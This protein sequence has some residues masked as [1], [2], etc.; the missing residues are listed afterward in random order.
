MASSLQKFSEL[1][2]ALIREASVFDCAVRARS[3]E[4]QAGEIVAYVVPSGAF[5]EQTV[6]ANLQS[7]MP[8]SPLPDHYVLLSGL[9]FSNDG[10]VDEEALARIGIVNEQVAKA[11]EEKLL[12]L[13][14]VQQA[15]VVI[16]PQVPKLRPLHISDLLPNTK[17]V[18]AQQ[19]KPAPSS[20]AEVNEGSPSAHKRVAISHGGTLCN[21]GQVPPTLQE[22]LRRAAETTPPRSITC[23]QADGSEIIHTYAELLED[24]EHI[25][26]GL[27][28]LG[29][30]PGDKVIFQLD[31]NQD[32]IPAFW[33]C[34]LGGFVPAPI[35]IAPTYRELNSTI[36]K[37][38]NSWGMLDHPVVLAREGLADSVRNAGVLLDLE[39]FRVET[40]EKLRASAVDNHWHQSR[41]EDVC[42]M[43]LTSGSTGLPKGVLQTHRSLMHRSASTAELT[44]FDATD[45][46]IN[47]FPLDHVGG[48]VMAHLMALF[49]CA[50]QIHIPTE[51]IL[52]EPL[53]WLDLIDRHRATVT[54]APNFAFGLIND[55]DKQ[56][57]LRQWDLSCMRFILNGGEAIV[58]KTARRFLEVLAKHGLRA[59]AMHPS[60]GMSETCSGIAFSDRCSPNTLHDEDSFVEVG[61]PIPG[62]SFRI[63]D[64]GD[65]A[66]EEGQIGRLQVTGLPVTTGYYK[67][68]ELNQESFSQDGWF[69]TGD[70]AMLNSGRLTITGRFKDVIIINGA[71]FFSHEIE[72]V[73]EEVPG[74]DVSYTAAFAVR[75]ANDNT[76]RLCIMFHPL[77]ADWSEQLALIKRIREVL[78][79]KAGVNAAWIIPVERSDIPKTAIGKIQ[80][81]VLRQRFEAREFEFIAKRIDLDTQSSNTLPNWFFQKA[82]TVQQPRILDWKVVEGSYLVFADTGALA[83]NLRREIG[84]RAVDW[85]EVAPGEAFERLERSRYRLN[86]TERSDYELLFAALSQDQVDV[87]RI[88]HLW[89]YGADSAKSE[90]SSEP[91]AVQ[92]RGLCSV[93]YLAQALDTAHS[94]R[95]I[96]FFV[97][98][99]R[100]QS[101][102][103]EDRVACEKATLLGLLKTISLEMPLLECRHVDLEGNS[104]QMDAQF[105]SQELA[106][107]KS[108][109][110]VAYRGTLRLQALLSQVDMLAQ[111][112]QPVLITES[113]LYLIT[114]GLGGIGTNLSEYLTQH[115]KAKLILV[116]RTVLPDQH[117][118][119]EAADQDPVVARRMRNYRRLE[120]SGADFMYRSLDI[121]DLDRLREVVSE[122]EKRWK[123]PLKGI[124]HLAG[125][126]NL[127][128]YWKVMDRHWLRVESISTFEGMFAPKVYGTRALFD[129]ISKRPEVLFIAFSS[130]LSYFGSSTW[131]AYSAASRFLDAYCEARRKTSHPNT[132]CFNWT[133]WDGVGMSEG[134]PASVA[135]AYRNMGYT[136]M[137]VS[138]ALDS[139]M[140]GLLR[141]QHQLAIGLDLASPHV[142]RHTMHQSST[143]HVLSGYYTLR[144][145]FSSAVKADNIDVRDRSGAK[146]QCRLVNVKPT[147]LADIS[148]FSVNGNRMIEI[149][150]RIQPRNETEEQ[151]VRIWREVLAVSNVSMDDK[152]FELGGDS[153]L[154]LRVANRMREILGVSVS[155]RD[156]FEMPTIAACAAA[157]AERRGES[158]SLESQLL[159]SAAPSSD[160]EL[161]A[162]IGDLPND[163]IDNLLGRVSQD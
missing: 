104:G 144:E 27:R 5:S 93:L 106:I 62:V 41:P 88:V 125:E 94:G 16:E 136:A 122:A 40:V 22:A 69:N 117:Q 20:T 107:P 162:M 64:G 53:K 81:S 83:G 134:G 60:W 7:A 54:W 101:T 91:G 139:M 57:H 151:I 131:S 45:V 31:R 29:L 135:E 8:G 108:H 86:P 95:P 55:Q 23:V 153:L 105:L 72:S 113:G 38:H 56:L 129:L 46:L 138:Q 19:S 154:A 70:L 137:S 128:Q 71:N 61:L 80:R 147:D 76:D 9:P 118:S 127:E 34:M 133:V 152:F 73:V 17:V 140:A 44:H 66:L 68:A 2:L 90:S 67:N 132:Y 115:F 142:R 58:P 103:E 155:L 36:H 98:S 3:S 51:V 112:I 47:W 100:S 52:K 120:S 158:N 145:A 150:K 21:P 163:E 32:F 37:L 10:T 146:T 4:G 15:A 141:R 143:L 65:Q 87:D 48:I 109:M 1:E 33:A 28:S 35:S 102:C 59:D 12:S 11:W 82:W 78:M 92:N 89:T 124:F 161:L 42:L 13:P 39:N 149:G 25:L 26:G 74:V 43:L 99:S 14:E 148:K 116:G 49:G 30:R 110:E 6:R 156:L 96:S 160:D 130:V 97:V 85:V 84:E 24:S 79:K 18:R 157:I 63:V 126:G 50:S 119:T 75:V 159:V 121:C 114:G 123:Q 77:M 111:P